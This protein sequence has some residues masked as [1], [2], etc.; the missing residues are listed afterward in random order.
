MINEAMVVV[1]WDASAILSSLFQDEYS[2][3]AR[4]WIDRAGV[5]LVSTLSYAE[6]NAVF[7]RIQ[8]E[9]L[10]ADIMVDAVRESLQT[11]PWRRLNVS[12][13]WE[14]IQELSHRQRL[15]GADLWHLATAISI[16]K[17]LPELTLLTFDK[18]LKQAAFGEGLISR[19]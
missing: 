10:M 4:T 13:Q 18:R 16:Q 11:G 17:D 9:R 1:Y 15:R 8:R 2:E 6:V 7:G 3:Q 19:H 12:P 5:H 14:D